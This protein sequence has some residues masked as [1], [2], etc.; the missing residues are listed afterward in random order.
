MLKLERADGKSALLT[1][2]VTGC[3]YDEGEDHA[4]RLIAFSE[5]IFGKY[6]K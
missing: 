4:E 5:K 3:Y 6:Y 1:D 2:D